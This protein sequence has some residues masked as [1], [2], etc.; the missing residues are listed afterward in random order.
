MVTLEKDE[1]S[2][3]YP[4]FITVMGNLLQSL[5]GFHKQPLSILIA[6]S[7][8]TLKITGK[9]IDSIFFQQYEKSLLYHGKE[10]RKQGKEEKEKILA[11]PLSTSIFHCLS[12]SL[13]YFY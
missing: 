9:V 4:S 13:Y 12:L 11:Q 1:H 6:G 8:H 3:S 10:K 2:D 7:Y 5:I